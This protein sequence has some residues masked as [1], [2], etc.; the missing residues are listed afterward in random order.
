MGGAN[1]RVINVSKTGKNK[2]M[3]VEPATPEDS[4]IFSVFEMKAS[5]FK[6]AYRQLAFKQGKTLP[7]DQKISFLTEQDT[8]LRE[9]MSQNAENL[10]LKEAN[11]L[12]T[13]DKALY[14]GSDENQYKR[15]LDL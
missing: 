2:V 9:A 4:L 5:N 6:E 8:R 3:T 11:N 15:R 10:F 13:Q 7:L 12:I 1:M 14:Q